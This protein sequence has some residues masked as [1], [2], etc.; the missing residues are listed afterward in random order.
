MSST[1]SS[2]NFSSQLLLEHL[3]ILLT[4]QS[5]KFLIRDY[6]GLD[7]LCFGG[8][9]QGVR[10]FSAGASGALYQSARVCKAVRT[11]GY[12]EGRVVGV[13]GVTDVDYAG[14]T[15][16]FVDQ[17]VIEATIDNVGSFSDSGDSGSAILNDDH[18]LAGLLFAGNGSHT[19]ANP[20]SDVISQ[21]R[22]ASGIPSLSVITA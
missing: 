13:T 21:L 4:R 3:T 20:I 7:R 14:G 16:R 17:I 1:R 18:E 5:H 2:S 22:N 11:T 9:I 15:A 19:M 10:S 12:T 6:D 8:A